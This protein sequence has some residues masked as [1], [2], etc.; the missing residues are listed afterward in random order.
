MKVLLSDNS[1]WGL[2]NFRIDVI[3]SMIDMGY[4]VTL[5]AP[6]DKTS[7]LKLIP[8]KAKYIPVT[9]SRT[10]T[11]PLSDFAYYKQL[12]K[13]YKSEKPDYIFHYTIKPN[14]YGTLAAKSLSIKSSAMVAGLGHVYIKGGI[15]NMVARLMYKFALRYPEWVMVLNRANYN[16]LIERKVVCADKLVWLEGGEGIN[17]ETFAPLPYAHNNKPVFLMIGRVLY[18][19][20][21]LEYVETAHNLKE[22]AVFRLMGPTDSNPAAVKQETIDADV[23]TGKIEYIPFSADVIGQISKCDCIVLPSYAEGLSR[24]LMEGLALAKPIITTAIAGCQETVDNSINGYLVEPKSGKSLTEACTKFINLSAEQKQDMAAASQA[25][26]Q[27]QFDVKLVIEKYM[28][29]IN[30]K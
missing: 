20:G 7:D 9:L 12:K 17:L 21:Y 18:D 14:I 29:I 23:A 19:K 2:L 25:K 5:V 15:K 27:R 3:N 10:G 26:A 22:K 8:H 24:V 1:L 16:I 13:I 6:Q 28:Q 30:K 4:N 11:N